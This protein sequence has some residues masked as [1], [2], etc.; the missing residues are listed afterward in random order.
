MF[1]VLSKGQEVARLSDG[2][3]DMTIGPLVR[4]WRQSRRTQR[5]PGNKELAA[6][7]AKVGFRKME[8]D[9]KSQTVSLQTRGMQLDLGGIAKGYAADEMLATVKK[10]GIDCALAAVGGDIAVSDAPLGKRGWTIE[11]APLTKKYPEHTLRLNN[12]AVSTSGDKEQ[13][14]IID[15]VRYSHIVDPHTGLGQTG[16]RSVTVIAR[17][18]ITS[19]SMT[20]VVALLDPDKAIAIIDQTPDAATL[21]VVKSDKGEEVRKSK[22]LSQYLVK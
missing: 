16:Q 9:A 7:K 13:F 6:A 19:D 20:K 15:G 8:L 3:F 1:F 2:A 14:V 21:M 17:R 5:L 22:R 4:L 10:L 11:V 12:M 18:G